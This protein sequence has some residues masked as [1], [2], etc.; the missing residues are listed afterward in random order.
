MIHLYE[1]YGR[2]YRATRSRSYTLTGLERISSVCVIIMPCK[3]NPSESQHGT[4]ADYNVWISKLC[5]KTIFLSLKPLAH[6]ILV[7]HLCDP[8]RTSCCCKLR[9]AHSPYC[10]VRPAGHRAYHF[11]RTRH[12]ECLFVNNVYLWVC[13]LTFLQIKCDMLTF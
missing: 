5:I 8:G 7:P 3:I 1:C 9:V 2:T 4:L 13:T 10:G 6:V 12:R 11:K